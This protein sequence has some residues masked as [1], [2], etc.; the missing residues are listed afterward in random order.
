M[1]SVSLADIRWVSAGYPLRGEVRIADA[2]AG[3]PRAASGIPGRGE[4]WAEPALLARL[5]LN[6][7]DTLRIG[8]LDA[9]V[10]TDSG[11]SPR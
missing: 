4:A 8:G 5:G 3:E 11:V 9:R 6:V 7:G 2:L 1:A 10:A